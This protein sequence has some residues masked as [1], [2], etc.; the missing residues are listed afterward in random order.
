MKRRR[1]RTAHP[2]QRPAQLIG[3]CARCAQRGIIN[4]AHLRRTH[5]RICTDCIPPAAS[6]EL[7]IAAGPAAIVTRGG[8]LTPWGRSL[9]AAAATCP[10]DR[11]S[12]HDGQFHCI[13]CGA[14][15]PDLLPPE[16]E[17]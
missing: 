11:C 3:K 10:H 15:G 4:L 6:D 5:E 13:A 1:P 7:P 16:L 12:V 14:E 17:L 9:R 8:E 2:A